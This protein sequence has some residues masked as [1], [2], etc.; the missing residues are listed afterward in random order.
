M[1]YDHLDKD[2]LRDMAIE[3]TARALA[4]LKD[5]H[6]QGTDIALTYLKAA[7]QLAVY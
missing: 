3:A 2:K 4:A 7:L 6:S 1:E 5:R